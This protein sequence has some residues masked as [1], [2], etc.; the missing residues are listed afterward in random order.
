V[1]IIEFL[2]VEIY[3]SSVEVVDGVLSIQFDGFLIFLYGLLH[4]HIIFRAGSSQMIVAE[5]LVVMV[6]S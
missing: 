1:S 3:I 2:L 6:E 5:T 4:N